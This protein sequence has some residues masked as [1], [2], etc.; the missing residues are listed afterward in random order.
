VGRVPFLSKIRSATLPASPA[1]RT[2]LQRPTRSIMAGWETDRSAGGGRLWLV[3]MPAL[4]FAR[5]SML[6]RRLRSLHKV[7]LQW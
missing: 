6:Y 5:Y 4:R 7:H 1:S 3:L 2:C